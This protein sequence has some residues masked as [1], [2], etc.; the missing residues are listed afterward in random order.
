MGPQTGR[1]WGSENR[2][3]I[4]SLSVCSRSACSSG[5]K[6]KIIQWRCPAGQE[7]SP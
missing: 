4:R 2:T 1:A 7:A 6:N 5:G 3:E